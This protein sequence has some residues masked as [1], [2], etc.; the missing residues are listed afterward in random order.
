MKLKGAMLA[1]LCL[2]CWAGGR[3]R[4]DIIFESGNHKPI[5]TLDEAFA[6]ILEASGRKAA[7]FSNVHHSVEQDDP[8]SNGS[9][10]D[11]TFSPTG[12]VHL[13]P[14]QFGF[15]EKPV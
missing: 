1:A 12:L 8:T 15:V 10:V 2:T 6:A 7:V 5:F 14:T 3:A 11:L 13:I 4:A 9:V